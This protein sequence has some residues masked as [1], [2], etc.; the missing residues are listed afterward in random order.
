MR[1]QA[2]GLQPPTTTTQSFTGTRL[3]GIRSPCSYLQGIE[4]GND[5]KGGI[6]SAR[7]CPCQYIADVYTQGV[8]GLQVLC[9][10]VPVIGFV[11]ELRCF[12]DATSFSKI[13]LA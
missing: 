12:A 3:A 1:L 6:G 13:F 7:T 8:C 10:G 9:V 2:T 5:N 4:A 11:I